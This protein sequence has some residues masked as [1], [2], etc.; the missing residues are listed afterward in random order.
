VIHS[1]RAAEEE[2]DLR[3]IQLRVEMARHVDAL[4]DLCRQLEA[5]EEGEL[6]PEGQ[7]KMTAGQ[8][9]GGVLSHVIDLK[10]DNWYLIMDG[11]EYG[12]IVAV[13]PSGSL[14]VEVVT[15][16]GSWTFFMDGELTLSLGA[17]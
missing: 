4:A 6:I 9:L 8:L 5:L 11:D 13:G 2:H 10:R 1:T 7:R 3:R 17:F 12:P 14:S 16:E 15:E